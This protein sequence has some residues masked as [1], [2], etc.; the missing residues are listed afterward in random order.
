MSKFDSALE[1]ARKQLESLDMNV[2]HSLLEKIGKSL[3]P[4]LYNKDA[5]YVA[6]TSN[7]ELETVRKNLLVNKFGLSDDDANQTLETVNKKMKDVKQ[8]HRAAY[9]YMVVKELSK[10]DYYS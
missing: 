3:G 5:S 2:D 6:A 7:T 4:A 1:T 8:K 10:E 9:Y